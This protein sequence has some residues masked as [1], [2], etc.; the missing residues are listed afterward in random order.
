VDTDIIIE[1]VRTHPHLALLSESELT[2]IPKGQ[3]DQLHQQLQEL[4][5]HSLVDVPH[6][7]RGNDISRQSVGALVRCAEGDVSELDDCLLS[8]KYEQTLSET[9]RNRLDRALQEVESV[10]FTS[11]SLEGRPP[12]WL[13]DRVLQGH[14][15]APELTSRLYVNREGDAIQCIP[16]EAVSH[17]RDEAVS[18]LQTGEVTYLDSRAFAAEF[19]QLYA[20]PG[21]ALRFLGDL[22][23]ISI[24]ADYAV[25]NKW[26]AAIRDAAFRDLDQDGFV[27]CAAKLH[28]PAPQILQD[29]V[30]ESVIHSVTDTYTAETVRIRQYVLTSSKYTLERDVLSDFAKAQASAQWQA[31]KE[32]PEKD[33]K[34]QLSDILAAVPEDQMLLHAVAQDSTVEPL[35]L[36]RFSNEVSQLESQN[37]AEFAIYWKER[38]VSRMHTYNEG[39]G[40]V[41]D[42]KLQGQLAEL[43]ATYLQKELLPDTLAKA[44][45]QGLLRSKKTK[46]NV[47]KLDTALKAGKKD[48]AGVQSS[49]EK[50]GKKQDLQAFDSTSLAETKRTMIGDMIRRMQKPKTEGPL[51]FLTLIVVLFAKHHSGVVYATGKFAPKL[52]KQLKSKLSA[53]EYERLE[54]WKELAKTGAL[55]SGDKEAMRKMVELD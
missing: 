24:I 39:L 28:T 2:V 1:L 26:L 22:S 41:K 10:N 19:N 7:V 47:Q 27:D 31:T 48:L 44:Q 53:E 42:Q 5:A 21:E 50:F 54:N 36:E 29:G 8:A 34:F 11:D 38:V 33:I 3:R 55:S 6:F 9:I 43:F 37:E 16:K 14:Q 25:S 20:L 18:K 12:I 32:T 35:L 13:I 49:I 15:Q 4:L 30:V 45:A 52:L 46:K 40:A 23:D 17:K 51:L